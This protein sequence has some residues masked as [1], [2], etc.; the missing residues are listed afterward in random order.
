MQRLPQWRTLPDA[1]PT[2]P[3][4]STVGFLRVPTGLAADP[5]CM[6]PMVVWVDVVGTEVGI[7]LGAGK[8]V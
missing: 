8:P 5:R 2:W 3:T 6:K 1:R 4:T 7:L